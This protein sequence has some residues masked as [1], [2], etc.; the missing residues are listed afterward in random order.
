VIVRDCL[1]FDNE[2]G[3]GGPAVMKNADSTVTIVDTRFLNNTAI[4]S[5]SAATIS[6]SSST[7][8]IINSIFAGNISAMSEWGTIIGNYESV[9]TI[10]NSTFAENLFLQIYDYGAVIRSTG[11]SNLSM[12]NSIVWESRWVGDSPLNVVSLDTDAS[13]TLEAGHSDIDQDGF[14]GSDGN[15]RQDPQF[16]AT[17]WDDSGTPDDMSDDI[18]VGGDYHLRT[19]SPCIDSGTQVG[20]ALEDTDFEGDPR[21]IDGDNDG[22]AQVDMGADEAACFI[23]TLMD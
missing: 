12:K 6:N 2:I 23:A 3:E 4:Q 21:V 9:C 7:C 1:F 8:T 13:S 11:H 16:V 10:T 22:V 18:W 5:A 17:G 19:G 15:I 14:E 20:V